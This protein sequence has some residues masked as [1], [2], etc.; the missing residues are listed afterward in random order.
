MKNKFIYIAII[1]ILVCLVLVLLPLVINYAYR[2]NTGVSTFLR[3]SGGCIFC[4][5]SLFHVRSS[6]R[7]RKVCV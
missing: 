5:Y 4:F 7:K 2:N 6:L 1:I 3:K